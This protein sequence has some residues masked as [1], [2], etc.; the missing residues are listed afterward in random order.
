VTVEDP[1]SVDSVTRSRD[2]GGYALLMVEERPFDG[3]STQADQL[4]EK[5]NGYVE[6]LQFGQ[7]A[8][9][10]PAAVGQALQVRLVCRQEPTGERLQALLQA[11]AD[12]FA[13]HGAQFVVEVI[14]I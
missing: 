3:S 4:R 1:D 9:D 10:Y 12:L 7:F 8:E 13:R 11:G 2:T 14:P 6:Y 5:I